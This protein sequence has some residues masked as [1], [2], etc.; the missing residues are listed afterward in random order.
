MPDK[1]SICLGSGVIAN[2]QCPYCNGTGEPN[3]LSESYFKN[4]I[5]QCINW[6][7]N[8]CPI[9]RTKCHHDATLAP[10]NLN[11]KDSPPNYA[12]KVKEYK[13]QPMDLIC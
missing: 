4:H 6:D 12:S 1:C 3:K 2:M 7:R 8:H 5:C 11:S 13:E 10:R 9:C